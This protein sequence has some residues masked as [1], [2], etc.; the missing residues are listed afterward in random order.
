MWLLMHR[1]CGQ[2]DR[3]RRLNLPDLCKIETV[4]A[5]HQA[6]VDAIAER[7]PEVAQAFLR[8][9]L[10]G[11]LAKIESLSARFPEYIRKTPD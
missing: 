9:H 6:I 11:T 7:Q 4:L 10:S 1:H 3:L 2:L 5:D 8:K